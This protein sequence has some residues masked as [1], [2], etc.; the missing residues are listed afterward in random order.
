MA[1]MGVL[2]G[3]KFRLDKE[4]TMFVL[5]GVISVQIL[6][7]ASSYI[8]VV[9]NVQMCSQLTP[10]HFSSFNTLFPFRDTLTS[11]TQY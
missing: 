6:L 4:V 5:C 2:K 1:S 7:F 10:L 3:H 9:L 8:L 11:P